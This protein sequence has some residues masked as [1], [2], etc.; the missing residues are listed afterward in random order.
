MGE[1][2]LNSI[3]RFPTKDNYLKNFRFKFNKNLHSAIQGHRVN[4]VI[5]VKASELIYIDDFN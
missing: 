2:T 4:Y 5:T 3:Y 1:K